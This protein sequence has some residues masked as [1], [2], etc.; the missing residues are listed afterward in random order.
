MGVDEGG[1]DGWNRV[2]GI[3]KTFIFAYG[4][5]NRMIIQPS[6]RVKEKV[7]REFSPS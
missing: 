5:S 1:Q 4:Q 7:E 3:K 6:S 2:S